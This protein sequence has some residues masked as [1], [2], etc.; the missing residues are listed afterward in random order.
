MWNLLSKFKKL[1]QKNLFSKH[2]GDISNNMSI[3][4]YVLI[5]FAG[6]LFT[7]TMINVY[8]WVLKN[9]NS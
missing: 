8:K 6:G 9:I 3:I 4:Y 2:K 7:M 1:T 5:G